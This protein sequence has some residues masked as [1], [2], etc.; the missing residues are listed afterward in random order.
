MIKTSATTL[1]VMNMAAVHIQ[2]ISEFCKYAFLSEVTLEIY[3]AI[4]Q[5]AGLIVQDHIDFSVSEE[6]NRTELNKHIV[7]VTDALRRHR[8][9][10][11]ADTKYS[12]G[13]ESIL[14]TCA[15]NGLSTKHI[16]LCGAFTNLSIRETAVGLARQLPTSVIEVLR[17]ACVSTDPDD[18]CNE[19]FWNRF[20]EPN[21]VISPTPYIRP[22]SA[23]EVIRLPN[24][25]ALDYN[26]RPYG[27][28][29]S[30]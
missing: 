21:I 18:E 6:L 5:K 4:A 17:L 29:I 12:D 14:T 11:F 27:E 13:S 16:Q 2:F 26:R 23:A 25:R 30:M 22:W 28:L 8:R 19:H 10:H 24:R 1:I 9:K 3:D 15:E 7:S 20:S